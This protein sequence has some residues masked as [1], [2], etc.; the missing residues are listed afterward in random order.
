MCIITST[1]LKKNLSY[2][3]KLSEK[4]EV[5]VTKNKKV[6]AIIRNPKSDAFED[7]MKLK[8]CLKVSDKDLS[9]ED[10]IGEEIMKKCGY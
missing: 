2:Y 7:F 6:I 4:E 8:G 10:M 9:T 3:L 5:H 1:E